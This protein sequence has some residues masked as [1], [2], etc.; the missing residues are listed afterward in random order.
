MSP[1]F[2]PISALQ[3]AFSVLTGTPKEPPLI[4]NPKRP[5]FVKGARPTRFKLRGV[6]YMRHEEVA[7]LTKGRAGNSM[8]WRFGEKL[9]QVSDKKEFFYCYNC[10]RNGSTQK[11]P[12]MNGTQNARLHLHKEHNRGC[13]QMHLS[14]D[15]WSAP[16]WIGII[17]IWGYWTDDKG[18]RQRRLL[19]FRR[20]YNSHSGENQSEVI[21]QVLEEYEIGQRVGYFVCDNASSND[22]AVR[23]VLRSLFPGI[24]DSE[25]AARRLHCFG[26][27]VNLCAQSLLSAS[28]SE[29]K[30]AAEELEVG[31]LDDFAANARSLLVKGPLGK[32]HRIIKYVCSSSQRREEF[33][34]IHGPK[35]VADFDH[36]GVSQKSDC[37]REDLKVVVVGR[38][39]APPPSPGAIFTLEMCHVSPRLVQYQPRVGLGRAV[40]YAVPLRTIGRRDWSGRTRR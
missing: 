33:A 39:Y 29:A 20:I 3:T 37:D 15:I 2:N 7:T 32:L 13:S 23:L 19:A 18:Q 8:V 27:I 28:D 16:S 5:A 14:F 38:S 11:L 17:C 6:E 21:L 12:S 10:E 30:Q 22:A 36:L 1:C 24:K 25:I 31:G 9:I 40:S 35:N 34:T 26:H 4:L